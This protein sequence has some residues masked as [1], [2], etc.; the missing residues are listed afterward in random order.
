[1]NGGC[2]LTILLMVRFGGW[3]NG[4]G[5][6][7][8]ENDGNVRLM[9]RLMMNSDDWMVSGC[10]VRLMISLGM[11]CEGGWMMSGQPT[12]CAADGGCWMS[13]QL[14]VNDGGGAWTAPAP[15][16]TTDG[17]DVLMSRSW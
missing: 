13:K 16:K 8:K 6:R 7:L 10:D 2:R 15:V 4:F 3:M 1:M 12:V 11:G 17:G 5:V 14:R 9:F